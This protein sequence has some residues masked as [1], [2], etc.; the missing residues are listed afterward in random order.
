MLDFAKIERGVKEYSFAEVDLNDL[1]DRTLSSLHYQFRM[2]HFTV[3]TDYFPEPITLRA[4]AD[5]LAE[6]IINL[7]SNAM[8][9]STD[10]K[11]I[12]ISTFVRNG[13]AGL[14]VRDHGIGIAEDDVRRLFEPFF[15]AQTGKANGVSG[16][17][18]G[19][20]VVKHFVDAHGGTI[21]VDSRPGEGSTFT[22]LLPIQGLANDQ[23]SPTPK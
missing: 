19:L 4:D 12:A 8:K 1:V 18:L 16:T 11:E 14:K 17:G 9:Y 23:P 5:A 15:R 3:T 21:D 7:I 22:I 10:H 13:S 6:S 2:Q 20:S